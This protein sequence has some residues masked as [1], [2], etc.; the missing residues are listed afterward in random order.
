MRQSSSLERT[1][2]KLAAR[3]VL[4]QS[5]GPENAGANVRLLALPR[6]MMFLVGFMV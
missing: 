4:A 1:G 5:A 3:E 2:L 6:T